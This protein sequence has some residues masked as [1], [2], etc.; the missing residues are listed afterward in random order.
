M[1]HSPLPCPIH[2]VV[3]RPLTAHEDARGRLIEIYREGWDL[4]CRAVQVHTTTTLAGVLRGVH[5]HV[6]HTDHLFVA[7]GAVTLGLHDLRPWSPSA[8][9]SWQADLTASAP[10]AVV[11]PPG[12]AHGAFFH[13]PSVITYAVSAYY[14]PQDDLECRHDAPELHFRWPATQP[15]LSARDRDAPTY[16]VFR[17]AF[18]ARWKHV[19]GAPPSA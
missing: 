4:G 18:L 11:I 13:E 12:V 16:E 15:T 19:H 2:G 14:D 8:G 1:S 6:R 7:A 3:V 10:H 17:A 5:V 9:A